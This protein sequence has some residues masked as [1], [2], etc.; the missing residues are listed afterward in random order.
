M[1]NID[2]NNE[3]KLNRTEVFQAM[4]NI[5]SNNERKIVIDTVATSFER[6]LAPKRSCE[7]KEALLRRLWSMFQIRGYICDTLRFPFRNTG[8][9]CNIDRMSFEQLVLDAMSKSNDRN[10][11]KAQKKRY[12]LQAFRSVPLSVLTQYRG[13]VSQD[14]QLF[15]YDCSPPELFQG[16]Q[17]GDE[18]DNM[19]SDIKFLYTT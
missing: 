2:S 19:F 4:G 8:E 18:V 14:C 10:S 5:D 3:R 17:D 12:F 15:G 7:F 9:T 13:H 16:R 11:L 1:G 6:T